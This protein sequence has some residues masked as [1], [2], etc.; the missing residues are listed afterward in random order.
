MVVVVAM[1]VMV[2]VEVM[3]MVMIVV[4]KVGMVKAATTYHFPEILVVL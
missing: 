2:I 3:G 4:M 1:V